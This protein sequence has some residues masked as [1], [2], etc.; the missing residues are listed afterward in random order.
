MEN[1]KKSKDL[2]SLNLQQNLDYNKSHNS[3]INLEPDDLKQKATKII[4]QLNK[5]YLTNL[6][7]LIDELK[8]R[9]KV[10][11][12]D[13]TE[14]KSKI[15]SC[16]EK[17]LDSFYEISQEKISL[18][19]MGFKG[20]GLTDLSYLLKIAK[21]YDWSNSQTLIEFDKEYAEKV[22]RPF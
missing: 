11:I 2:I 12:Y 3:P 15:I 16:L 21:E 17:S 10:N 13:L 20:P 5:S 14:A 6:K 9:Q 1:H 19:E 7:P 22:H 4:N 18:N 8:M